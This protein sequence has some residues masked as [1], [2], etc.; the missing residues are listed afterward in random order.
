MCVLYVWSSCA[1]GNTTRYDSK[2]QNKW[3]G[4]RVLFSKEQERWNR[5]SAECVC[6]YSMLGVVM[7]GVVLLI[8]RANRCW[9]QSDGH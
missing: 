9:H 3:R 1:T 7:L 4:G 2:D 6:L 5:R 8:C